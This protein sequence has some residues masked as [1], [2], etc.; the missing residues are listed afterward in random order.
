MGSRQLFLFTLAIGMLG[1]FGSLAPPVECPAKDTKGKMKKLLSPFKYDSANTTRFAFKG[2][3]LR[4]EVE[5]PLFLTEKYKILF[6]VE[7]MPVRPSVKIFNKDKDSKNRELL[8]NSED[9]KDKT[10]FEYETKKWT[11]KVFVDIEV[12]A[13]PDSLGTGCVFFMLGYE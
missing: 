7:G 2:K 13:L 6:S 1:F 4:K 8:F 12:P 3:P 9:H 5:V 11:R 10:E